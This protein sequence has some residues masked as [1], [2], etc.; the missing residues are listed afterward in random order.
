M[1]ENAGLECHQSED[2]VLRCTLDQERME[3]AFEVGKKIVQEH[4]GEYETVPDEFS[5][6]SGLLA[7]ER[8]AYTRAF[9]P[10]REVDG[11]QY[12]DGDTEPQEIIVD[13]D[14]AGY[15][16]RGATKSLLHELLE[17]RAIEVMPTDSVLQ[18]GSHHVAKFNEDSLC[19]AVNEEMG[20]VVCDMNWNSYYKTLAE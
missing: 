5:F 19:E 6:E 11:E 13:E 9:T 3:E 2:G 16:P 4:H 10:T 1:T 18:G 20:E 7:E 14:L 8:A 17:W 15:R 12:P